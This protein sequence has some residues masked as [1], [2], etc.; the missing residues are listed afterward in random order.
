MAVRTKTKLLHGKINRLMYQYLKWL[1]VTCS[2]VVLRAQLSQYLKFP[3]LT[4][5]VVY[6]EGGSVNLPRFLSYLKTKSH[7]VTRAE[8]S[9][10]T[11]IEIK[12]TEASTNA[13]SQ[14]SVERPSPRKWE[15]AA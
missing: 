15:M 2:C 6:S 8:H 7:C 10:L 3:V 12:H 4:T 5:V 14:I 1:V 11:L 9:C 13:Y